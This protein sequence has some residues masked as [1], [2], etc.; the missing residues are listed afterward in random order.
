MPS[1]YLAPRRTRTAAPVAVFD[2]DTKRERRRRWLPVTLD[3]EFRLDS[4]VEAVCGALA[5]RI[6]EQ[7]HP[8]AFL[9]EAQAV[10]D[11]VGQLCATAAE[12]VANAR[13]SALPIADRKRARDAVRTVS[14]ASVPSVTPDMLTDGTWVKPLAEHAAHNTEPLAGLL[15]RQATERRAEPT[16]SDTVLTAL[17][18]L[19]RAALSADRRVAKAEFWRTQARSSAI[20]PLGDDAQIARDTLAELG[21]G[22]AT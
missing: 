6:A 13:I 18:D 3:A 19:D 9:A 7:P 5:A 4:E 15:G 22:S 21:I 12:L 10:A 16:V 14:R 17:R 2:Q 1:G 20:S 11:A 8:G